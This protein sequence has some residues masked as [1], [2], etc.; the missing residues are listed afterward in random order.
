MNATEHDQW[1]VK[2]Q[3]N[4]R[5]DMEQAREIAAALYSHVDGTDD[6]EH[7]DAIVTEMVDWLREGDF[8]RNAAIGLDDLAAAWVGHLGAPWAEVAE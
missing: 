3:G 7:R 6:V 8:S 5:M 4:G 2:S 1:T